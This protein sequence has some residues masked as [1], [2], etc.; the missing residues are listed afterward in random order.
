MKRTSEN[1]IMTVDPMSVVDMEKL[2]LIKKTVSTTNKYN[3]KKK[4]VVL[5]GRRPMQT[6]LIRDFWTGKT[7]RRG[8]DWAGNIVGGLKNATRL[9]VYIYERS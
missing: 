4:R 9:D 6:K 7:G 2:E 8:Y 1:Y 3:N 5:R